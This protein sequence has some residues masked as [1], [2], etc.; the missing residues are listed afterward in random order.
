MTKQ[1]YIQ[2]YKK[3]MDEIYKELKYEHHIPDNEIDEQCTYEFDQT[4]NA[5]EIVGYYI[6]N[7]EGGPLK[8]WLENLQWREDLSEQDKEVTRVLTEL[9][10]ED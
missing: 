2:K 3:R 7:Y 8:R 1:D 4:A 5:E 10:K 6:I 9:Y